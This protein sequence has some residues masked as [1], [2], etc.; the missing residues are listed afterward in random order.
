LRIA[1]RIADAHGWE[2]GLASEEDEGARFEIS[3]V[4]TDE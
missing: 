4:K 1:K 2:M 3:G